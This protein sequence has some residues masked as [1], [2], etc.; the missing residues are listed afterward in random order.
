MASCRLNDLATGRVSHHLPAVSCIIFVHWA[1]AKGAFGRA[2]GS[3]L[4]GCI[5]A[6]SHMTT[7]DTARRARHS[8]SA[9]EATSWS[10]TADVINV[11][12]NL[13][14]ILILGR[15]NYEIRLS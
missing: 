13:A 1:C 10:T 11:D 2:L 14:T 3:H 15:P 5:L 12:L 8:S 7:L 9:H 6:E 4:L